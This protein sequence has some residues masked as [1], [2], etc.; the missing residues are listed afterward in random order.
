MNY[1][2]I[3]NYMRCEFQH[4]AYGP[5]DFDCYGL[6]WHVNKHHNNLDLPRFDDIGYQME[7]INNAITGQTSGD[8]W[9]EVQTPEDFDVVVLR[10]AGEAYHVGVWLNVDGGKVLHAM[11]KGVYCHDVPALKRNHFQ[12]IT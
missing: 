11:E 8:D 12:H 6:V 4:G 3:R 1:D 7:R 9:L 10:R 5:N 2:F